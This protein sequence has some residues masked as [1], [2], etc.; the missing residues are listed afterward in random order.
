MKVGIRIILAAAMAFALSACG[1]NGAKLANK[2][3][4]AQALFGAYSGGSSSTQQALLALPSAISGSGSVSA[5]AKCRNGNGK[6]TVSADFTQTDSSGNYKLTLS[7]D[8]CEVGDYKDPKS[9]KLTPVDTDGDVTYDFSGS[10]TGTSG[11]FTLT[12]NGHLDFSGGIDDSLDINNVTLAASADST[13]GAYSLTLTG[14]LKTNEGTFTY[15]S[16]YSLAGVT[17]GQFSG[18]AQP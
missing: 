13:T 11:A 16:S 12:F 17:T 8:G 14:T 1:G 7:F 2:D 4:A 6:V 18:T 10:S 5:S 15:D 3:Q 9:G